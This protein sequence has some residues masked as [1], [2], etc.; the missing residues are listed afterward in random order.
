ML[1]EISH[2]Q[3][4]VT[5]LA[6]CDWGAN[7]MLSVYQATWMRADADQGTQSPWSH[8]GKQCL[9]MKMFPTFVAIV[10]REFRVI[11]LKVFAF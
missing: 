8:M 11:E 9:Q 10:A 5:E 7:T 4:W 1:R 2:A 3:H 6:L